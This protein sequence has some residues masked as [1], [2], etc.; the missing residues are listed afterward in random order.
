MT[1][2]LSKSR[3]VEGARCEGLLWLSVHEPEA[4]ELAPDPAALDR[5]EQGREVGALARERLGPGLLVEVDPGDVRRA[6][7]ATAEALAAG[8]ARIFEASFLED[9]VFVAADALLR[10]GGGFHLVEVKSSVADRTGPSLRP[11]YRSDLGVQLHVLRRAG[12]PVHRVSLMQIDR[13]FELAPGE[14]RP[15]L[16]R[17]F[18]LHDV[19]A[20]AE[21]AAARVPAELGKRRAVL[22]GPWPEPRVGEQCMQGSWRC[23]FFSRC[24]RDGP[25]HVLRLPSVGVKR[26]LAYLDRGIERLDQVPL[27]ELGGRARRTLEAW[28]SGEPGVDPGLAEALAPLRGRRVGF[29]DF[30]TVQ[31]AVPRW[32]AVRPWTAVPVQFSYHERAPDGSVSHTA[33][34]AEPGEDPRL[35][36][37]RA[38]VEAAAR[39][40]LVTMYTAFERRQ[41]RALAAWVRRL[42]PDEPAPRRA[43]EGPL[44]DA[45]VALEARLFDLH[46]V[47]RDHVVHPGFGGSYRIKDVAPALTGRDGYGALAVRDG[48]AAAAALGRLLFGGA[49]EAAGGAPCGEAERHALREELLAYCGEDT[50]AMVE[51]LEAL[52]RLAG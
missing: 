37:A 42:W 32:P 28:W 21:A 4:P 12:V 38:L 45:L 35:P 39:A 14:A 6:V 44:A 19:T 41:I 1:H 3:Y 40:D 18:V 52:E 20:E 7:R 23:P 15:D 2:F 47:V 17:L 16:E 25:D 11:E 30:E 34:L 31:R 43:G 9:G 46:P 51:V 27:E 48:S 36:L 5:M 26:A 13:E 22:A 8:E 29:L 10:E 33:W 49:E 24:W 50:R